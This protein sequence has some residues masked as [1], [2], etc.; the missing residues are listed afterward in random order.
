MSLYWNR[1]L[2]LAKVETTYGTDAGPTAVANAILATNMSI[3]PMEGQDLSRDR[4]RPYFSADETIPV[5]VHSKISF[6]T[7]LAPSGVAGTAPAWGILMRGAGC[8]QTIV[9]NTSVTYN[10]VTVGHESLT[11][12]FAIDSDLYK[13][14]G[15]RGTGVIKLDASGIP[16]IE[17]TYT[18]LFVAPTDGVQSAPTYTSWKDAQV[19]NTVNTT[20]HSINGVETPIKSFSMNMGGEVKP[21][22]LIGSE[23]VKIGGR[24]EQIE[25]MIEAQTLAT[26]NP[27]AMA[28]AEAKV[29]LVIQ[30][31]VG[32]GNRLALNVPR[33]QVQRPGSPSDFEGGMM[34]TLRGVPLPNIGNDQWTLTL[35]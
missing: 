22:F 30:H 11:M 12:H 29:P 9:A 13:L 16:V 32:A 35:T 20:S 14:K 21:R 3:S 27:Y 4:E 25:L 33:W 10:P 19:A 2:L 17:W 28:M 15:A 24:K 5:D 18:G 1:K 34:R 31:G 8:A 26:L 7:E 23:E 6:T